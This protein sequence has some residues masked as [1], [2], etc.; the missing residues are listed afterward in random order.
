VLSDPKLYASSTPHCCIVAADT[1]VV[2]F[3][4]SFQTVLIHLYFDTVVDAVTVCPQAQF[5]LVGERN[6]SLH[7]IYVPLKKT[8]LTKTLLKPN[9][10]DGAETTFK[11]LILHETP[12]SEGVYDLFFIVND[13]FLHT[14][15]VALGKIQ[16]AIENMDLVALNKIQDDIL[17]NFCSTTE[18]HEDGCNSASLL[19]LG[20]T[21]HLLIGAVGV[22]VLS[23]WTMGPEQ[24][25]LS[26][27]KL[28]D[29]AL[30]S[31]VKKIQVVDNLM[32]VLNKEVRENCC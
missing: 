12:A 13:G 4:S 3:D 30:M 23:L 24:K 5:L 22:S 2:L 29:S 31:E 20:S 27:T 26:L 15:N 18:I 28:L 21:V 11:S 16:R 25:S 7:I 14:S 1:A 10:S 9:P 8:V 32:Y 6:G 17:M 19:C